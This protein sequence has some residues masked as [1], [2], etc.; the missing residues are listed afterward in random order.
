VLTEC[1]AA[2]HWIP[3]IVPP[4][5]T[6][7]KF[8]G[9]IKPEECNN[10]DDNCNQSIDEGLTKMCYDGPAETLGVGICLPGEM[11]CQDGQWG[12][13][14][15]AGDF[16]LKLCL[17]QVLPEPEDI[18]KD[19]LSFHLLFHHNHRLNRYKL[20]FLAVLRYIAIRH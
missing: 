18:C 1:F 20:R 7:D 17:G 11:F 13:Y 14:T 10:H 2:C 15:P 19:N 8:K 5:G 4:G 3:V 6:C 12:A 16:K 9:I